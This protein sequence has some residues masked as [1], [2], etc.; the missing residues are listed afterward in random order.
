M[1]GKRFYAELPDGAVRPIGEWT[2]E[3]LVR[4]HGWLHRINT[5][6][7]AVVFRP[8]KRGKRK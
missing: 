2:Y 5:E 8:K 4:L 1:N 3:A 7:Q 6:A